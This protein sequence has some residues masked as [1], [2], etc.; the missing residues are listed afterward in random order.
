ML[1]SRRSTAR[2]A[3]I[4]IVQVSQDKTNRRDAF[5]SNNNNLSIYCEYI[6][7]FRLRDPFNVAISG[8]E[9]CYNILCAPIHATFLDGTSV[10]KSA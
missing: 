5:N 6:S 1:H 3:K 4:V 10:H 2:D 8:N 9:M 7:L